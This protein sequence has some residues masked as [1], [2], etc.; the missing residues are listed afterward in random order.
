MVVE[1]KDKAWIER[2]VLAAQPATRPSTMPADVVATIRRL[3]SELEQG[4]SSDL[5][6]DKAVVSNWIDKT[7][8]PN[9]EEF[10]NS[11]AEIVGLVTTKERMKQELAA[12]WETPALRYDRGKN[13]VYPSTTIVLSDD[14]DSA[15]ALWPLL[16]DGAKPEEDRVRELTKVWE[17]ID[18]MS[19][20]A[21]AQRGQFLLQAMLLKFVGEEVMAGYKLGADQEWLAV[22]VAGDTTAKYLSMLTGLPRRAIVEAMISDRRAYIRSGSV[23]LLHP[24]SP[25]SMRQE[26]ILPYTDAFRRKSV[27]VVDELILR[28][29]EE[30]VPKVLRAV[31]E[32]KPGDG[33]AL[34]GLIKEV[35]GVE[36]EGWLR[37]G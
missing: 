1:A 14:I 26:A 10:D 33:K 17:G 2:A 25:A 29:G 4:L 23:D 18:A 30:A 37:P 6:V 15:E 20:R 21:K 24:M 12:G 16:Y 8:I 22:G 9:L 11:P 32:K 3:H 35:T 19:Q 34:A 28:G 13:E 5:D 31:K 7:L 27:K 36:V